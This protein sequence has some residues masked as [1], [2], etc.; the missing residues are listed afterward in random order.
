MRILIVER[1][2][3]TANTIKRGLKNRFRCDIMITSKPAD[4]VELMRGFQP[5]LLLC[6]V[7]L[8]DDFDSV[9]LVRKLRQLHQFDI[10]YITNQLSKSLLNRALSTFPANFLVEPTDDDIYVAVK[11]VEH[12]LR[13]DTENLLTPNTKGST[14][15]R[16]FTRTELQ[17]LQLIRQK[18]NTKEIAETLFLSPST[19][20]N[21]RHNICAKLGLKPE[22]NAL[23]KWVLQNG[24]LI[25]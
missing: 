8:M 18:K 21:Y 1:T 16:L 6:N 3:Y 20:K 25:P 24:Q 11:L 5:Q 23:L 17:I 4:A 19:I 9:A 13:V 14:L 22:N 10:I 12:A 2:I 15:H 7:D